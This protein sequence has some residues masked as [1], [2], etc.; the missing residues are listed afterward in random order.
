[1]LHQVPP[2]PE[3]TI[4]ALYSKIH[5]ATVTAADMDYEGS[6]MIDEHL[7]E[8]SGMKEFQA[9]DIYD[10][11]N[12]QRIST[13]I[14]KGKAHSGD[15]QVNG[16]AA[17]LINTGDLIIIASYCAMP[18]SQLTDDYKPTVVLCDANNKPTHLNKRPILS[19]V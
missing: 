6:L 10:I 14:I 17:H 3:V 7:L 16:A 12:G 2:I 11:T 5:R 9:I 4:T 1:M 15:I 18:L 8:L 19:A 13:Y